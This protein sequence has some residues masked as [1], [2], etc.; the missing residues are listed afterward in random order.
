MNS[1]ADIQVLKFEEHARG[2]TKLLA[3]GAQELGCKQ[4]ERVFFL[5]SSNSDE[6]GSHAH[7]NCIQWFTILE[8]C[9]KLKVTDGF[10]SQTVTLKTLG[11]VI[12]VP[13]GLWVNISLYDRSIIAVFTDLRYDERDYI[14]DWEQ[15]LVFRSSR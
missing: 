6:R 11:E 14:R 4:I 3:I 2:E 5:S 7:K 10:N 15:Y 13:S 12:K 9:A 8:G 1:L